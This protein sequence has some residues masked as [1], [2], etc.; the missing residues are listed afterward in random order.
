MVQKTG[1]ASLEANIALIQN[2]DRVGAGIARA[3]QNL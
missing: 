3:Y 2:N 1:G